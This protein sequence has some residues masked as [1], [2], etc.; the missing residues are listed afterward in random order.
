[1]VYSIQNTKSFLQ[2]TKIREIHMKFNINPFVRYA[3]KSTYYIKN[4]FVV[5]KDCHL[6]YILSGNGMLEGQ[7]KKYSLTP[8][9][10]IYF[11]YDLPYRVSA[12]ENILFYTV[13]FDFN[14]DQSDTTTMVPQ[15]IRLHDPEKVIR[16]IGKELEK[17]FS[18]ILYLPNAQWAES[19]V[20][21]IEN[22]AQKMEPG[23]EMAQSSYMR[24]ILLSLYRETL[25]SKE[26]DPLCQQIKELIGQNLKLNN[27]DISSALN[28]HPFYLND[29]F[30]KHEGITLHKYIIQQRVQK[31][32][33]LITTTHTSLE[34]IA[35]IC[36]FSSQ[37]H[38]SSAFK[39]FYSISPGKLRMHM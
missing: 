15:P 6:L 14:F 39:S 36:G 29:V 11:P 31:A 27:R 32:H 18:E 12:D 33:E 35:F 4:Q 13:N 9:T 5:A 2:K 38:L 28:Y 19:M 8:G 22:E 21:A 24:I 20:R 17:T 25:N 1:M 37:A 30:K 26:P 34:E 3:S 23:Y 16:S 7:E 10:L